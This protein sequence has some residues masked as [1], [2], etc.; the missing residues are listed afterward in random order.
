[1]DECVE[2][3]LFHVDDTQWA[4]ELEWHKTLYP[5]CDK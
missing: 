2:G 1:V 3:V 5:V 4:T